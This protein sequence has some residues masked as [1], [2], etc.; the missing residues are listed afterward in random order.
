M[1]LMFPNQSRSFDGARD[2]VRFVGHDN[3]FEVAFFIEI[4]ALVKIDQGMPSTEQGYF[5]VF[6]AA[7]DAIERVAQRAYHRGKNS[8]IT[9]TA[10]DIN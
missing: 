5:T 3:V 7:R 9:L 4:E 6:D 8:M 2:C 10:A 1:A